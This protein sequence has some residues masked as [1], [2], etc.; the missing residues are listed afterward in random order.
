M[1]EIRPYN[2]KAQQHGYWE[3]HWCNDVFLKHY[4]L[5]DILTGYEEAYFLDISGSLKLDKH[6]VELTYH[7]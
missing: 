1:N 3:L 2:D 4:Y 6:K 7:L 5:N